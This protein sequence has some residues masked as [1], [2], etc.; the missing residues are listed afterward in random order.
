MEEQIEAQ[1]FAVTMELFLYPV[2]MR[3]LVPF[4]GRSPAW[5]GQQNCG[6]TGGF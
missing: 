1:I 4:G 5:K 6:A 2:S 3:V